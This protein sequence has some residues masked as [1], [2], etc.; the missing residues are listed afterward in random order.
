MK[1]ILS[2][3]LLFSLSINYAQVPFKTFSSFDQTKIA[4]SDRGEG[5]VILLL[6]GFISSGQSWESAELTQELLK[7]GYR[8]IIPDL[9]GNGNS[10][11]LQN[12]EA[13]KNDAEIK[14]VMALMSLL[15]ITEYMAI[16]YSRG[17]IILAKLLT[18][19]QRIK[20]A[21]IGGMGL[22]F[23]DQNWDR[24]VMFQKAFSGEQPLND[25]TRGAVNYAQSIGADLNILSWLQEFQPVTSV[26]ELKKINTEILVIA[27]DEDKD[28]GDP[29][30]LKDQFSNSELIIIKG[31]HNNAYKSSEFA[32]KVVSFLED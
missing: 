30:Q 14:D 5:Q 3:F 11:K 12:P 32:E 24:R 7:D 28:N 20:K 17:A 21:V 19:D 15:E 27:G 1:H 16:G 23:T 22:D 29:Q 9:R 18:E 10:E 2:L 4:Y 8:V 25:V 26:E 31:D 13:Y 6:H